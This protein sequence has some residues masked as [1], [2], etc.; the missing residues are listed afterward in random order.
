MEA[1]TTA[2]LSGV[3]VIEMA[4]V[5]SGPLT[6]MLL[7][8]LGAEVIKVELPGKGDVF[9]QWAGD[10]SKLSP[11]FAA[12]NR[13][14]RSVTIDVRAEG[15]AEVYLDL[16]A[17][18]DVIVENFR[19]GTLN[20]MGVGYEAVAARA[21]EVI[22]CALSGVGQ[23]GPESHLPTYDAIAQA[24]SGLTSQLTA[25][26]A[27]EPV[28]PPL[29]DQL[30]G[31]YAA[32]AIL[33]ALYSRA[34]GGSGQFIDIS[35]LSAAMAFQ[36]I[37]TTSFL[38]TGEV[39]DKIARAK[40]SQTYAVVG[41]DG[42]PFAIHLSTPHKFW[43]GLTEVIGRPDLRDDPRFTTKPDRIRHYEDL[44]DLLDEAFRTRPR[45]EWLTALRDA[46]VP[47]GPINTIGE[48]LADPQVRHL[49]QLHTFGDGADAV[50]LVEA[51]MRY[52]HAQHPAR[53]PPPAIGADT[54]SVLADL[55]YD[56]DHLTQLTERGTV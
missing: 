6:G 38:M 46:D 55:G 54:R 47:A 27:P 30:T 24:K 17:T 16:A 2:P 40:R 21:P 43:V 39:A 44:R 14:K 31:M 41:A 50:Q 20:R 28:G 9:R 4:N 36:T 52:S 22:Y 23:T 1:T 33:G 37:A 35:M 12:F 26:D 13:R 49:E 7:A 45:D 5:I 42:R 3:R 53:T 25:M 10:A 34:Q 8:D 29:S 32:Y 15:G 19:P 18:A 11:P 48:A 56:D 51:P